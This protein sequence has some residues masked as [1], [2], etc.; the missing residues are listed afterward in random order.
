VKDLFSISPPIS[1]IEACL[2]IVSFGNKGHAGIFVNPFIIVAVLNLT[3]KLT[4]TKTSYHSF[5]LF[6][7]LFITRP[8]KQCFQQRLF[9]KAI[10]GSL[11]FMQGKL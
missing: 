4:D 8:N 7:I 5:S 3:N 2:I 1:I 11:Q 10:C 6:N 9:F